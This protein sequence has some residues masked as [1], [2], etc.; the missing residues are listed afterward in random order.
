MAKSAYLADKFL[1]KVLT[2]ADFTVSIVYVG[3]MVGGSEVSGG[4]YARMALDKTKWSAAADNPSGGGRVRHYTEEVAYPVASADWGAVNQFFLVDAD[5][6]G[7]V[8]YGP[9]NIKKLDGADTT[10]VIN[11]GG[12][13]KFAANQIGVVE[14]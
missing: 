3:L 14:K 8:L 5:S 1:G 10:I 6:E 13:F 9:A 7:N 4:S 11:S 12:Q 2:D